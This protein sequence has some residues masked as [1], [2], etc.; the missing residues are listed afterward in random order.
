MEPSLMAALVGY[1]PII[2]IFAVFYFLVLKP[3]G[4]AAK[5]HAALVDALKRGDNVL[6]VSGLMARVEYV[7]PASVKLRINHE[8]TVL[9]ARSSVERLLTESEGK[10]LESQLAVSASKKK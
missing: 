10:L 4:D 9:M 2:L 8:D 5:A 3:Q 1:A 6:M 7:D